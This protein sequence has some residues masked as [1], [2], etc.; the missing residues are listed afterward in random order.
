MQVPP[1]MHGAIAHGDGGTEEVRKKMNN[2]FAILQSIIFVIV[3]ASK[4]FAS[5]TS[6]SPIKDVIKNDV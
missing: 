4:L 2:L 1:L 6:S 5:Q 3:M